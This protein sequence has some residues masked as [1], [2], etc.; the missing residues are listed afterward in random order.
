MCSTTG[1]C[2]ENADCLNVRGD[3]ICDCQKGFHGDGKFCWPGDCEDTSCP[4]N[5]TCVSRTK[6]DCK[7]G[8]GFQ[9]DELNH[10]I[11][12]D[13]C[14]MKND[15]D[16]VAKCINVEGS[17]TCS[18]QLGFTGSGR[19]C[20]CSEGSYVDERGYC[21]D[22]DECVTGNDCS[23]NANCENT[24]GSYKCSCKNGFTESGRDCLCKRGFYIDNR[25]FCVDVDECSTNVA[26][27]H[28]NAI[29]FNTVGSFECRCPGDTRCENYKVLV[30]HGC[31]N[32]DQIE[33]T[34]VNSESGRKQK[35]ECFQK[36]RPKQ[37]SQ[38]RYSLRESC[39]IT[40]KNK[41]YIY[42]NWNLMSTLDGYKVVDQPYENRLDFYHYRGSCNV[43]EE[44]RIFLCFDQAQ[45]LGKTC[46]VASDP[47]DFTIS[48]KNYD[49]LQ[50]PNRHSYAA[51]GS[52]E[53][54]S[55]SK[56]NF[57]ERSY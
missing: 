40:W 27:C 29:C 51:V 49:T 4:V 47:F 15:C 11:D 38:L 48:R 52:S 53:S 18:C 3:F 26:K 43:M 22:V 32:S 25:G 35:V 10:C 24:K 16:E 45:R 37:T 55:E 57:V 54:E 39:S 19:D 46:R 6:L 42:G 41:V 12:V 2:D 56:T 31:L 28:P 33:A 5:Q 13:E 17:Y 20:Q 30:L 36:T 23:V 9:A 1:I 34:I 50:S 44:E 8:E 7:C 21:V 14:A